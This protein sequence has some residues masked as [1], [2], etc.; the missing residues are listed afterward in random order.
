[1]SQKGNTIVVPQTVLQVIEKFVT[2][3]R[4]DSYIPKD[5]IDQLETLLR[6]GTIP[7]ADDINTAL[8]KPSTKGE[9]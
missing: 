6:K 2:A 1:M 8:F 4:Q 3:M 7:K 9:P 5:A